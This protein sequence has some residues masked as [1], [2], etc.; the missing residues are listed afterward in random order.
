MCFMIHYDWEQPRITEDDI[1][2]WKSTGR[3]QYCD[4]N[5]FMSSPYQ[6]LYERDKLYYQMLSFGWNNHRKTVEAGFHSH[7]VKPQGVSSSAYIL[8]EFIIPKGCEYFYN[9][10]EEEYCSS[11]IIFKKIIR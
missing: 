5:Q 4:D 11:H 3:Y 9:H 8:G 2:C 10:I 7:S 6:F 1:I